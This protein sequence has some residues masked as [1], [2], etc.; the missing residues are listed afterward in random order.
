MSYTCPGEAAN[1]LKVLLCCCIVE[2]KTL[3]LFSAKILRIYCT[4]MSL[5][6]DCP[7]STE[8]YYRYDIDGIVKTL[9]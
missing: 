7:H 9:L 3:I 1:M 4:I 8:T 6:S 5:F 2:N